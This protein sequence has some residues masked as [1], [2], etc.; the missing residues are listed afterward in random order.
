MPE[1]KRPALIPMPVA[2]AQGLD[3]GFLDTNLVRRRNRRSESAAEM[4]IDVG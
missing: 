4:R 2:Q 3:V 1:K